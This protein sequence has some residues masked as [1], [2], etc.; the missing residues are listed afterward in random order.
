MLFF[1]RYG[2]NEYANLSIDFRQIQK[3]HQC[4]QIFKAGLNAYFLY[5]GGLSLY[6]G[7]KKTFFCLTVHR[8]VIRKEAE[9]R[10]F[11]WSTALVQRDRA[12]K[13]GVQGGEMNS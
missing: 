1:Q 5:F 8:Q 4:S 10:L 3:V 13:I 11:S 12:I 7:F 6:E 2:K 9:D